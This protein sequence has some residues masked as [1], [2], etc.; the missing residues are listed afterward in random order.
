[1]SERTFSC[2]AARAAGFAWG[3][4]LAILV[5]TGVVHLWLVSRFPVVTWALTAMGVATVAWLLADY[6]ARQRSPE[7]EPEPVA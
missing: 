5:E 3:W 4:S 2:R 1:M 7:P 6:R